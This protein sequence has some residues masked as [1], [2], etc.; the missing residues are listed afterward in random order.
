[1]LAAFAVVRGFW[2]GY[3]L[4]AFAV[5]LMCALV[6][7]ALVRRAHP[8]VAGVLAVSVLFAALAVVP[9]AIKLATFGEPV[10]L[11]DL[12]AGWM[13]LNILHGSQFAAAIACMAGV[14]ALL[15]WLVI[16]R[17]RAVPWGLAGLVSSMALAAA[18]G[19]AVAPAASAPSHG[20]PDPTARLARYGG[21]V[22]LVAAAAIDPWRR[23][24]RSI[25]SMASRVVRTPSRPIHGPT[26]NVYMV[27]LE[28]V[29]D[30]RQMPGLTF[31]VD[32][33]DDRFRGA[34]EAAGHST[35]L[36]PTFGGATA[37]AEFEALCGLP[38]HEGV[39]T[40]TRLG[41]R[42]LPCLPALFSGQGYHSV[43]LHPYRAEFWNRNQA[44]RAV[45][46]QAYVPDDGFAL[47]EMDGGFL[48]DDA[49]FGQLEPMLGDAPRF[50]F[51][52]TLSS[53]YPYERDAGA[54]PDLVQVDGGDAMVVRYANALR[55]STRAFMDWTERLLHDDPEALIVAFGDHAPVLGAGSGR[56]HP[57][58]PGDT[59]ALPLRGVSRTRLASTPLLVIDGQRGPLQV[60]AVPLYLLHRIV[61]ERAGLPSDSLA[62]SAVALAQKRD[63]AIRPFMGRMLVQDARG[64]RECRSG[65]DAV[66]PACARAVASKDDWVAIREDLLD[67]PQQLRTLFPDMP[68]DTGRAFSIVGH[69]DRCDGT[70]VDWGPRRGVVGEGFNLQD[71]GRSALWFRVRG[72]RRDVT[73]AFGPLS[74]TLLVSGGVASASFAPDELPTEAVSWPVRTVCNGRV[75]QDLGVVEFSLPEA[76]GVAQAAGV[77]QAAPSASR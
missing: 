2:T 46:F 35:A 45:G 31:S 18:F 76:L 48:A 52:V 5:D 59:G 47:E 50:A 32:P 10:R 53:H 30:I 56:G 24:E 7:V 75:L 68:G 41:S 54:R 70:V 17:P 36:V 29:W 1:M 21:L 13:L 58:P 74:R 49:F 71:S 67:G 34:L 16:T 19:L 9:H 64:L 11:S 69:H 4:T 8:G 27:L 61:L 20:A 38:A 51:L 6:L 43:A 25:L 66:D 12:A 22:E 65:V 26:R 39:V 15:A 33:F 44:Y 40:F 28:S 72:V 3:G 62:P 23:S 77:R 73:V 37:N 63:V 57:A 14:A 60:G 42:A 55:Y